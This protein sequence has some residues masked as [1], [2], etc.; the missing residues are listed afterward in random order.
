MKKIQIKLI[1]VIAIFILFL[2][3]ISSM[4]FSNFI[5]LSTMAQSSQSNQNFYLTVLDRSGNQL[6]TD[7]ESTFNGQKAYIYQWEDVS[8]LVLNFDPS[9]KI[10]TKNLD[11]ND[12]EIYSMTVEIQFVQGFYQEASWTRFNTLTFYTSTQTGENSY[13]NFAELKPEFNVDQGI[14]GIDHTA[15]DTQVSIAT[16]GIYRF[17]LIINGQDTLSDY[18]VI[19]P[20]LEILEA[21]KVIYE[22]VPSQSTL[23]NAYNFSLSNNEK[24]KYI[25]KENLT[26][27]AIGKS[28]DGATYSLTY[29]DINSGR[30]DFSGCSTALAETYN[31]NGTTFLFDSLGVEGEWQIWCEY[32]YDG[33]PE[34]TIKSNV[35]KVTIG[36]KLTVGTIIWI[37]IGVSLLAIGISIGIS[38]YKMKRERIY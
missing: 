34:S 14:T 35:Q 11:E 36:N 12:Q 31:R 28:T 13:L 10:P 27:F 21:P 32:N 6:L 5:N 26:W 22:A 20:T 23:L 38:V 15:S 18:F 2:F 29:S 4:S 7:N 30:D 16:W 1:S 19:E 33:N 3:A 25:K 9:K 24:F 17:R 8:K 37:V